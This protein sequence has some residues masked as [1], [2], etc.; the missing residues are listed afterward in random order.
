MA[1]TCTGSLMQACN[2]QRSAAGLWGSAKQSV[3]RC[4]M[5]LSNGVEHG[6]SSQAMWACCCN[7][8][9]RCCARPTRRKPAQAELRPSVGVN[10][11]CAADKQSALQIPHTRDCPLA[12]PHP[13]GPGASAPP[14]SQSHPSASTPSSFQNLVPAARCT[15]P[16]L[17]T[18]PA[19]HHYPFHLDTATARGQA[20]SWRRRSSAGGC[21]SRGAQLCTRCG[22]RYASRCS[23]RFQGMQGGA[24]LFVEPAVGQLGSDIEPL[25]APMTSHPPPCP[26]INTGCCATQG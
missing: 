25:A 14:S 15:P 12:T 19:A 24:S 20:R 7:A 5:L 21:S 6:E 9:P 18:P 2:V 26:H 23:A 11:S 22:P 16:L 17:R 8:S 3:I 10:A 1:T 4:S 13:E